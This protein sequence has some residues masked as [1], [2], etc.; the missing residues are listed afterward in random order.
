MPFSRLALA[1]AALAAL[2]ALAPPA[3]AAPK[4]VA[5]IKP[6]HSLIAGV[7]AGVAEPDLIVAGGASPHL[8][9]L[10]PSD[11]RRLERADIV[12][13]I[14]PILESF[15]VKPLAALGGRAAVVELD[16]APGVTLL[17]ARAGGAWEP[18]EDHR[19]A[20][21]LEQ[22][23]HLW[24]DP[25]NAK[26]IVRIAVA[27]LAALDAADA[28]RY[29]QNGAALERRLDA[30]DAALRQRLAAVRG[31][32][33]VVFHDAYQYFER[34]Y[35][36]AAIGSITVSPENLPSAR[37]V[38]AIRDKVRTLDARCV[39]REPQFEPR[40]VD[41]VIAGTKARTGVLDPE[42]ALLPRGPGLYF[43][44]LNGLADGLVRCLG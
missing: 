39:F 30:L 20:S 34:R 40:L 2:C 5:S 16:R 14:G 4:V 31:R 23:G 43:A 6:I 9:T 21:A 24:L 8:Y 44:L 12:F 37:R 7:M 42:G 15:L 33:F 17:P 26:A 38:Q 13:W 1:A 22:D 11:A 28:A 3:G 32:R 25:E 18:D 10:K 41:V 27:R 35:D 19:A 29:A 36:L